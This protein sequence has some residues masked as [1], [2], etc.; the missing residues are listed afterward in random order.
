LAGDRIARNVIGFFDELK[1]ACTT[2][3]GMKAHSPAFSRR[4]SVPTHCS[5]TPST[6]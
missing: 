1:I 5:A 6:T 2:F 4:F 3:F